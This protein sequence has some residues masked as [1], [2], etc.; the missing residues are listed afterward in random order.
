[1]RTT[2][3]RRRKRSRPSNSATDRTWPANRSP[4]TRSDVREQEGDAE[5]RT[6]EGPRTLD[7]VLA[8]SEVPLFE[9]RGDFVQ[10]VEAVVGRGPVATE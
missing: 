5:V 10:A 9:S 3:T 7:D 2:E 1:M 8:E 6:P 4:A